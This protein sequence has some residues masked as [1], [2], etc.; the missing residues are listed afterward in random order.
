MASSYLASK[1]HP[2][3]FIP[4]GL[5][6]AYFLVHFSMQQTEMDALTRHEEETLLEI[7]ELKEKIVYHSQAFKSLDDPDWIERLMV[8]KLGVI[9]EG[10]KAIYFGGG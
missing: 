1:F 8:E 9:P 2:G 6:A 5:I 10:Y 4:L 3:F 7:E